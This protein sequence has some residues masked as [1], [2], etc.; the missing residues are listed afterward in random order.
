MVAAEKNSS[1]WEERFKSNMIRHTT[2]SWKAVEEQLSTFPKTVESLIQMEMTGGEPDL[3]WLPGHPL[4]G[5]WV[6]FSAESPS[7]RRSLCYDREA[8]TSRKEA[9]PANSALELAESMGVVLLN[10]LEY[11]ELQ[12]LGPF[13]RKT[14][15][16]LLTPSEL[17]VKGGALFG[18]HRYGRTFFYHNGV[19][20]YYAA[21]GF[22]AKL[23]TNWS[24]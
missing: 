3:I 7:G 20:S 22:R 14:S 10:E 12:A 24:C 9:A 2:L 21:R 13:D 16:W 5:C 15:S 11:A 23:Y 4:H 6:D 17:R 19:Q 18:D 8:R 1:I